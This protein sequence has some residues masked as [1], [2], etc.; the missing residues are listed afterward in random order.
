MLERDNHEL[1][2]KLKAVDNPFYP[3]AGGSAPEPIA[4]T[5]GNTSAQ[6]AAQPQYVPPAKLTDEEKLKLVASQF[7]THREYWMAPAIR[8]VLSAFGDN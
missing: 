4:P 6:P 3:E 2:A 7:K 5:P 1:V 8:V